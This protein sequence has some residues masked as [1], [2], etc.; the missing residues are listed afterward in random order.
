MHVMDNECY[1]LVKDCIKNTLNMNLQ[2]VPP[3]F[4]RANMAKKYIDVFRNNFVSRLATADPSFPLHIWCRLMLL[5]TT[6]L[7]VLR[8]A[9]INPN[10]WAY[11][12]LHGVFDYNKTPLAPQGTKVF[13]HGATSNSRT[14]DPPGIESWNI[15]MALDHH[16]CYK[17]CTLSTRE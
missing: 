12:F 6:T 16:R 2:L 9:R 5:A 17:L 7:N 1:F 8:P 3:H 14:W 11:E 13:A 4:H 10:L 15:G